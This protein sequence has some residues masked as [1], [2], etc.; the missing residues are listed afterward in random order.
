VTGQHADW[1]EKGSRQVLWLPAERAAVKVAETGLRRIL[2][3]F[4]RA[5]KAA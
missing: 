4:S 1:A 3:G 2:T 5:R